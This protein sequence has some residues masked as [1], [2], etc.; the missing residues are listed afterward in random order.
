ME[1]QRTKED[2][3]VVSFAA[4][5]N[6]HGNGN[7][8]DLYGPPGMHEILSAVF[9]LVSTI[10]LLNPW[11]RFITDPEEFMDNR[12]E[13]DWY[14]FHCHLGGRNGC[15]VYCST[16]PRIYHA[17]CLNLNVQIGNQTFT[18]PACKVSVFCHQNRFSNRKQFKLMRRVCFRFVI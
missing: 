15:I 17:A 14:C 11:S 7:E 9:V 1:L 5:N 4:Q 8:S 2:N 13:H 16:C 10:I 12:G 18:C 3:L 6:G